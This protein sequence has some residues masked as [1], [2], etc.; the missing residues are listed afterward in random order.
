MSMKLM[1]DRIT[2]D[3]IIEDG[4]I[5]KVGSFLNQQIDVPFVSRC[6]DEFYRLFE[7]EKVTKI[8]TIEASGIGLACLCAIPFGVPVVFAKKSRSSNMTGDVYA[9]RVF[10]FT[11]GTEHRIILP[12]DFLTVS[13]RVLL[14]DDFLASGE[15]L[16]G[17]RELCRQAGAHIVGAGVF[18]E[19]KYQGGGDKLRAEGLRVESLARITSMSPEGGV[20]FG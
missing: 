9:A 16:V 1:E 18:V 12:R 19:K 11:H 15:A 8:L 5:L 20:T 6:A 17:L 2:R 13:D 3:G 4:E 14:I 10:S 7:N